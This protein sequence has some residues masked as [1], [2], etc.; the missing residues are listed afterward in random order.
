MQ[1][2]PNTYELD[3]RQ[4]IVTSAGGILFVWALPENAPTHSAS[5]AR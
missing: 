2:S 3:G 1:S 4:Y 5:K